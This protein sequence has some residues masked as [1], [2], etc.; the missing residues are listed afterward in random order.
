[1]DSRK[2]SWV[3][4]P[5]RYD[6]ISVLKIKGNKKT[7][8]MKYNI[9]ILIN[10]KKAITCGVEVW[11]KVDMWGPRPKHPIHLICGH[12][13]IYLLSASPFSFEEK[14]FCEMLRWIRRLHSGPRGWVN[15]EKVGGLKELAR[16]K[17]KKKKKL[18]LSI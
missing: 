14:Y 1:M 8:A 15:H 10:K 2:T 7:K 9:V 6:F 17:V 13:Q 18:A 3:P 4:S 16:S 12:T 11:S 5:N